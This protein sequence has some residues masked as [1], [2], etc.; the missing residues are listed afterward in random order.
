MAAKPTKILAVYDNGG[1]SMD[2][3]T[4]VTDNVVGSSPQRKLYGALG[5]SKNP[6]HPQ[7]FS[8]FGTAVLGKHLGKR[9]KFAELPKNVQ[10]HVLIRLRIKKG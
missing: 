8:Q 5:C 10:E 9:I 4:I 3:Y 6:T 1:K 2:Q 7:G